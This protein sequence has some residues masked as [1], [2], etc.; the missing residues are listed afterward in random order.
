[1]CLSCLSWL[2]IVADWEPRKARKPRKENHEPQAKNYGS[3][4]RVFRVF[5]G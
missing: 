4:V 5:R 3:S 1:L 2:K